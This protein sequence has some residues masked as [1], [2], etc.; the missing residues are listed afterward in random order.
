MTKLIYKINLLWG[1]GTSATTLRTAVFTVGHFFID[2]FV[3]ST[4]T[5]AGIGQATL[6]SLLAPLLNGFWYWIL[7]R[8]WTQTH[9]EKE[10]LFR[11]VSENKT[12]NA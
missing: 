3:I 12:N 9:L 8:A 5:G 6:A 7:D 10:D 4:V 11:M 1:V 2:F